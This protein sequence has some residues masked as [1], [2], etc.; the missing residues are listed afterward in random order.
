MS[1]NPRFPHTCRILRDADTG[2]MEDEK[3]IPANNPMVDD[4]ENG[5]G[6]SEVT[7]QQEG[8]EQSGEPYTVIYEGECR[9]YNRDTIPDNG[10]VSASVRMLALPTKQDEWTDET[11]PREGDRIILQR[12]GYTEYG[13]VIDRYPG[14]LGTHLMWRYVR[15]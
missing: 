12:F 9:S 7:E 5:A 13:E 8:T 10:A 11:I 3:I 6:Q 2:P 15:N 1:K 4:D 14:N